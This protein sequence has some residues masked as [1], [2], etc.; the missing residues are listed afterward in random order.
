[1]IRTKRIYDT[2]SPRDGER[3]LVMRYWPRG[4]RRG[5]VD[6]WE[7]EL[8]PSVALIRAYRDG[9]IGWGEFARRYRSEMRRQTERIADLRTRSRR[10][11][12]TLL[13]SCEEE[14][15]CHR[16]LLKRLVEAR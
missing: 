9:A 4:V 6:A 5:A 12:V 13:C 10:R 16:G 7:K 3:L 11:T 1:M 14:S 15:R 2:P 8:A